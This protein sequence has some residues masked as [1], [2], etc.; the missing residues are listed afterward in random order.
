VAIRHGTHGGYYQ[1]KRQNIAVCDEC[2][3]AR[4]E[5]ARGY[6]E[7]NKAEIRRKNNAWYA[8]NRDRE[9]EK[10]RAYYE[11]NREARAEYQKVY[12]AANRE[13]QLER[14]RGY[15]KSDSF[16]Q[17]ER[18]RRLVKQFGITVA[19][20]DQMVMARCGTCD[21]CGGVSP[22]QKALAIDHDHETG[23]VRGLLCGNCN[24][25]IGNLRDSSEL[26][27]RARAYLTAR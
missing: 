5:Y 2:Q 10:R 14:H 6:R 27:G 3:A 19:E 25:G 12:Y 16:V 21:V 18:E 9:L 15:R 13:R 7:A 17:R 24:T 22:G 4:R 26:L 20:Y 1:H 23:K 8:A 11:D